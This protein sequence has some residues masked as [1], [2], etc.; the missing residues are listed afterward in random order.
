MQTTNHEQAVGEADVNEQP[1]FQATLQR[2]VIVKVIPFLESEDTDRHS[3]AVEGLMFYGGVEGIV[4]GGQELL[5]MIDSE[6]PAHRIQAAEAI[7]QLAIERLHRPLEKLY[8]DPEPE[9]QRAAIRASARVKNPKL[10][11][12]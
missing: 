6:D 4:A 8:R 3:G 9:V 5:S 2:K 11:P 12:P 10:L 7:G 1:D